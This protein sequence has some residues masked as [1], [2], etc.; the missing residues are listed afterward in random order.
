MGKEDEDD[1][2]KMKSDKNSEKKREMGKDKLDSSDDLQVSPAKKKKRKLRS[3]V[4]KVLKDSKDV[5]NKVGPKTI[6]VS[7]IEYGLFDVFRNII[8]FLHGTTR[9]IEV[10]KT[11]LTRFFRR[12]QS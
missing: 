6:S 7:Y 1:K 11:L 2:N 8:I 5:E 12:R 10:F 9:F 3:V 4:T